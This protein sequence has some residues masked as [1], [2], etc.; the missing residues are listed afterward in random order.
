M[1]KNFVA[2][3]VFKDGYIPAPTYML[4]FQYV[5]LKN[6]N[7]MSCSL[8]LFYVLGNLIGICPLFIIYNCLFFHAQLRPDLYF[9]LALYA[10]S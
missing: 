5:L 6:E 4:G 2:I 9:V 3:M 1:K 8:C 7:D 10:L